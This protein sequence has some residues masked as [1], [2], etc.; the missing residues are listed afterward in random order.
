MSK[1]AHR[2]VQRFKLTSTNAAK[3]VHDASNLL[4]CAGQSALSIAA[5]VAG[6]LLRVSARSHLGLGL[7]VDAQLDGENGSVSMTRTYAV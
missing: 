7:D 5:A 1:S 3:P 2:V 4:C 6:K